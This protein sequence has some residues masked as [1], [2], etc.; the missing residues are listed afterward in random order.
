MSQCVR[1]AAAG[2]QVLSLRRPSCFRDRDGSITS[3]AGQR[4]GAWPILEPGTLVRGDGC[5]GTGGCAAR[6][7]DTFLGDRSDCS[8]NIGVSDLLCSAA[9]DPILRLAFCLFEEQIRCWVLDCA[10]CRCVELRKLSAC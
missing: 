8:S 2:L 5:A 1:N 3:A 4:C 6:C 7:G 10:C 9:D